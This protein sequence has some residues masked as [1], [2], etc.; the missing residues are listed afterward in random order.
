MF[1]LSYP[2]VQYPLLLASVAALILTLTAC[3]Q[4]APQTPPD[5]RAADETAIRAT[6]SEQL[7]AFVALDPVKT[8]S[9]HTDDVVAM[10]ADAPVIQGRENMQ[11]YLEKMMADKPEASWTPVKVEVAR[12]GDLAYDWGTAK[13]NVKDKKG[14]VSETTFKYVSVWRK[15]PDGSCKIAVETIIPDPAKP[16]K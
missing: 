13:L 11:K 16:K 15:Q 5:T 7:K 8:V 3:Q 9:F 14:K 6:E 4:P 2:R 1:T 10:S 12:S